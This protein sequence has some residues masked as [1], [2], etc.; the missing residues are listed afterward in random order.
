MPRQQCLCITNMFYLSHYSSRSHFGSISTILSKSLALESVRSTSA[1]PWHSSPR[2]RPQQVLCDR[3]QQVLG[4][5][6]R[7]DRPQQVLSHERMAACSATRGTASPTWLSPASCGRVHGI[8]RGL[9]RPG[10]TEHGH[11]SQL[12]GRLGDGLLLADATDLVGRTALLPPLAFVRS[13][14]AFLSRGRTMAG[15]P[16]VGER[17]L[18][19]ATASYLAC[20]AA[21]AF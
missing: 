11:A 16:K 2:D 17:E 15:W 9:S 5:R 7:G 1:S 10:D 8:A 20:E 18:L 13:L 14:Q 6:V 21:T 12:E 4:T 3:P 19:S